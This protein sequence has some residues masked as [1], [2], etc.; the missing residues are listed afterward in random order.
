MDSTTV[1]S[2]GAFDVVDPC[3][4]STQLSRNGIDGSDVRCDLG[5]CLRGASRLHELDVSA[6][7]LTEL[8]EVVGCSDQVRLDAVKRFHGVNGFP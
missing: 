1:I 6:H 8:I 3:G 2:W 7:A 5:V 4:D